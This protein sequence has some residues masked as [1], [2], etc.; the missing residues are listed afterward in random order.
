MERTDGLWYWAEYSTFSISD[1]VGQYQLTVDGYSG[2]AGDAMA[3]A[4][5]AYYNAN[6]KMFSTMD[7]DND[8]HADNCAANLH[9]GWWYDRCSTSHLTIG[10]HGDGRW[11]TVGTDRDVVTSRMLLKLN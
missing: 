4:A 11:K 2:D 6:G 3:N 1:E 10:V 8:Q 7:N 9:G 5:N